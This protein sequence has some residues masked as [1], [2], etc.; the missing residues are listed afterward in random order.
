MR[1]R[2]R[3]LG[4]DVGNS[5][6]HLAV[7]DTDG[8]I[9]Y[10]AAGAGAS[11]QRIG[12]AGSLA[13]I[14]ECLRSSGAPTTGYAVCALALAGIDLPE[15]ESAYLAAAQTAG[16]GASVCVYNDTYALLRAG[17]SGPDGI[18]VVAGAGINCV[19][20]RGGETVRF[21]S[22]GAISG[23]WGGGYDLG[24]GALGLA[25]R[26]E[27]GRG[28][29]TILEHD[30]PGYFGLET[31]AEVVEAVY[32]ERIPRE[33]L[34][35]LAPLVLAAAAQGDQAATTLTQRLADEIGHFA[36]AAAR[37][38]QCRLS[39]LPLL[40]GGGLLRANN[41]R[42]TIQVMEAL[43][44]I[45]PQCRPHIATGLPVTGAILLAF[46]KLGRDGA[47]SR[48]TDSLPQL[49]DVLSARLDRPPKVGQQGR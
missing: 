14:I 6:T 2:G 20:V 42:L 22:L 4:V 46:D 39:D 40:L 48:H 5:K 9:L 37:R 38:L 33:R 18:A 29:A 13:L 44:R 7:A 17:T 32:R 41:E 10:T 1:S 31:P 3:V 26:S 25:C 15:D 23:D 24:E 21:H 27:D 34:T 12:I 45:D 35:E 30:I 11:P 43:H 19:G 28:K 49:A 16:L 8:A 36:G 47:V